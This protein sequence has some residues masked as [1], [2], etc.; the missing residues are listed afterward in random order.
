ME[1]SLPCKNVKKDT[2]LRLIYA[3]R[4]GDFAEVQRAANVLDTLDLKSGGSTALHWAATGGHEEIVAFLL[5]RKASPDIRNRHGKAPLHFAAG[6][7]HAEIAKLL[8]KANAN[9]DTPDEKG[10]TALHWAIF[11]K[12]NSIAK[13]LIKAGAELNRSNNAHIAPINTALIVG[14]D[15]ALAL[16]MD[17][18]ARYS[19]DKK[20]RNPF[21]CAVWGGNYE[22]L[23]YLCEKLPAAECEELVSARDEQGEAPIHYAA[24]VGRADMIELLI[25]RGA[26]VNQQCY[27]K[28]R[29]PLLVC[30][31]NLQGSTTHSDSID[32]YFQK[33]NRRLSV[34][35]AISVIQVLKKSPALDLS[36]AD[37]YEFSAYKSIKKTLGSSTTADL[38]INELFKK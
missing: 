14:N 2:K 3:A 24:Q 1:V 27:S 25:K 11:N 19:I 33:E 7:G 30:L 37:V 32:E 28:K 35:A 15:T 36:L 26:L 20:W 38:L 12:H 13:A 34:E 6:F 22:C 9:L 8:I 23:K 21:H 5:V 4:Q 10:D 18:G 16:L 17:A 29:T 31:R